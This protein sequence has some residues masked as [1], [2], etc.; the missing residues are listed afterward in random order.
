MLTPRYLFTDDFASFYSYFLFQVWPKITWS[1]KTD[2]GKS[3]PSMGPARSFP[4]IT[5]RITGSNAQS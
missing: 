2:I 5:S 3:F 4:G 1:M